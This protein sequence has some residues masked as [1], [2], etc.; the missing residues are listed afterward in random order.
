M[1]CKKATKEIKVSSFK[2]AFNYIRKPNITTVIIFY[3]KKALNFF[4]VLSC[5]TMVW[6]G[7]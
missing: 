4:H 7:Q 1:Q 3:W 2:L 5:L 6:G